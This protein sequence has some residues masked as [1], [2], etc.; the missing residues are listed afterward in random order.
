MRI[1]TVS[2]L[3]KFALS[4]LRDGFKISYTTKFWSTFSKKVEKGVQDDRQDSGVVHQK[5]D[6]NNADESV[7]KS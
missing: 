7:G 5:E 6:S 4:K 1:E 2:D 3:F